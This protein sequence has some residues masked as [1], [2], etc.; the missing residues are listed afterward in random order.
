VLVSCR[1]QVKAD[2]DENS[3]YAAMLAAQDVAAKVMTKVR[4]IMTDIIIIIIIIIIL[5][6]LS[7]SLWHDE[8]FDASARAS[9]SAL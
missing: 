5:I 2:R 7:L 1:S 4:M 6:R 3:P 9:L 8:P